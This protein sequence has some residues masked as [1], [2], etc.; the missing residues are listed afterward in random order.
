MPKILIGAV[1]IILIGGGVYYYTQVSQPSDSVPAG[2]EGV[3]IEGPPDDLPALNEHIDEGTMM[4]SHLVV[5]SGSGYSPK[6]LTIHKG[7]TVVFK[8]TSNKD[9]WPATAQHPTH[10]VYPGSDIDKCDTEDEPFIFDAC[11]GISPGEEW[12]FMFSEA[13]KWGYHDHLGVSNW[14]QII[15]EE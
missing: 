5:F 3:I 8:N 2:E 13:G 1:I 4:E 9:T 12:S 7:D 6:E 14:G 10:T 11:R 15:V